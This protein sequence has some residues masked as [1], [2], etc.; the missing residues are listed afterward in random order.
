MPEAAMIKVTGMVSVTPP[1]WDVATICPVY[2][3][4]ASVTS[5][6]TV[7]IIGLGAAQ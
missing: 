1:D 3:P 4:A 5:G 7:T 6:L 2:D